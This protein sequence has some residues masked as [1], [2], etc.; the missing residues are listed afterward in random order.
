M[1]CKKV[2]Y[3][4]IIFNSLNDLCKSFNIDKTLLNNRLSQGWKLEDA[5]EKEKN[6]TKQGKTI[7]INNQLFNSIKEANEKLNIQ[8]SKLRR[9]IYNKDKN[10]HKE[11][12]IN[13]NI[14]LY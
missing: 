5:I 10:K 13:I 6:V 14:D 4:G 7:I 8:E 11:N 3:K 9:I 1:N 2:E 12:I